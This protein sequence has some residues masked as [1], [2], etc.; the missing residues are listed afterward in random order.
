MN[1]IRCIGPRLLALDDVRRA[2]RT[3]TFMDYLAE[4][5]DVELVFAIDFTKSNG[6]PMDPRQ[7]LTPLAPLARPLLR[8]HRTDFPASV[9]SMESRLDSS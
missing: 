4:G 3:P 7:Y 1:R 6:D 2:D 9:S 8:V 5:L